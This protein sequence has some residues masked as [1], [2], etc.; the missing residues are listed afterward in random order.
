MDGRLY[1][2]GSARSLRHPTEML[3]RVPEVTG[4]LVLFCGT[5][6]LLGG[7]FVYGT[8]WRVTLTL[9]GG[10]PALT[11]AYRLSRSCRR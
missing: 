4:D 2:R 10:G 8:A 3:A 11:H 6:R 1:Q 9:P 7:E 5:M